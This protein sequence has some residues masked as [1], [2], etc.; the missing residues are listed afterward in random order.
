M[1]Q[2]STRSARLVKPIP[3]D[4]AAVVGDDTQLAEPISQPW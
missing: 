1:G 3:E 2:K 4:L